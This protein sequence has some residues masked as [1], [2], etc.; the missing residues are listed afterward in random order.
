VVDLTDHPRVDGSAR[1]DEKP[2]RRTVMEPL[3]YLSL[4]IAFVLEVAVLAA[5]GYAG[6]TLVHPIVL[7]VLVGLGVPVLMAVAWGLFAAPKA[8]LPLHGVASVTFQ[9]AWFGVGALALALAGRT[10]PAITLA[11]VYLLNSAAL[12][13]LEH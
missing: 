10:T 6:F 7:R 4:L 1:A 12:R 8:S 3:R 2:D 5:T 9:V 11:A 13:L